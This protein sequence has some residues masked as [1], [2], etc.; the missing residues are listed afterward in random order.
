[1]H[2]STHQARTATPQSASADRHGRAVAAQLHRQVHSMPQQPR[3]TSASSCTHVF[4]RSSRT[5]V[6]TK[7]PRWMRKM[8]AAEARDVLCQRFR[9]FLASG[10]S[11]SCRK[12]RGVHLVALAALLCRVHAAGDIKGARSSLSGRPNHSPPPERDLRSRI[13]AT[14][15]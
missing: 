8:R 7:Q 10:L 14:P 11:S 1:M 5:M 3:V 4:D 2:S 13:P 6:A 12:V 15:P 9:V